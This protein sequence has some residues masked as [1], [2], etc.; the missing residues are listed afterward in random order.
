[1]LEISEECFQVDGCTSSQV[2]LMDIQV[3]KVFSQLCT[4]TS[5]SLY[6]FHFSVYTGFTSY[7]LQN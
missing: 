6:R 7:K 5:D 3:Y 2:V 4:E 1:V